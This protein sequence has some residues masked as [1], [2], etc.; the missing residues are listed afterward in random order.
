MVRVVRFSQER[1]SRGLQIDE[2]SSGLLWAGDGE[3]VEWHAFGTHP[4]GCHVRAGQY[5][6]NN[7]ILPAR[8][9]QEVQARLR[10]WRGRGGVRNLEQG[11]NHAGLA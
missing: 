8:V 6:W 11:V 1:G 7:P 10:R 4:R 9:G 3:C 2:R 5:I